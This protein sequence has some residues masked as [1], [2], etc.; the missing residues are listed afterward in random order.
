MSQHAEK[1][2]HFIVPV[3]YYV[4]TF[5]ALLVLTVVTVAIARVDFGS[6]NIIIAMSVAT[7]KAGLVGAIFM[8]LR[9]DKRVNLTFFVSSILFLGIF[10]AYVMLDVGYRKDT[11]RV[12]AGTHGL[13]SPVRIITSEQAQKVSH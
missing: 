13:K 8:G 7:L 11:D 10:L 12:E 4:K 1:H 9:W 6:W 2:E 5:L 3:N